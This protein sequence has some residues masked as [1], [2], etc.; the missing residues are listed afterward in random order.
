MLTKAFNSLPNDKIL[1]WSKCT[2][3]AD[4]KIKVAN[5]IFVFDRAENIMGKGE[6]AGYQYFFPF[7]SMF[8]K[9][10]LLWVV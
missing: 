4:D 9:G 1:D 7:P 5:M 3:F 10:F 2:A 6:N 8:S